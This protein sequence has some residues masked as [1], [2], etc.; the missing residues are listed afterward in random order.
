M[1]NRPT[2]M[3]AQRHSYTAYR[4]AAKARAMADRLNADDDEASYEV[5]TRPL[6]FAIQV[7]L[8]ETGEVLFCL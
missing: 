3:D 6:G 4:D 7:T 1:A 8:L 2:I 5:V